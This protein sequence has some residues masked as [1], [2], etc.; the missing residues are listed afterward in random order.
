[1]LFFGDKVPLNP[2]LAQYDL[3]ID[4]VETTA[5]AVEHSTVLSAGDLPAYRGMGRWDAGRFVYA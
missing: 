4:L 2:R 1:M 5:L 3:S